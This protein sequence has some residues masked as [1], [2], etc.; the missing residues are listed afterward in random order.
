M[1][2]SAKELVQLY[3]GYLRDTPPWIPPAVMQAL[4]EYRDLLAAVEDGDELVREL[5]GFTPGPWEWNGENQLWGG[6]RGKAGALEEVLS[7]DDDGKDYGMHCAIVRHHWDAKVAEANR[8][9]IAAAPT[10]L[11]R[12]V[13]DAQ[14]IA[15][16][17]GELEDERIRLAACGVVAMANTPESAAKMRQMKDKYRS[18]SL[19][20]VE[21][22]VDAEMALRAELASVKA[23]AE[24][25][26]DAIQFSDMAILTVAKAAAEAYRAAHPKEGA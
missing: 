12:I 14:E 4:R 13:S 1:S 5:R 17:K 19:S 10:L 20:D 24:A 11:A 7:A 6:E 21:R 18:A 25:M 3:E 26:A 15:A 16:L 8:R 23:H 9:L 22:A 2:M